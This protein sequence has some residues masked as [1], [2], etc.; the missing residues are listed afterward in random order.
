MWLLVNN[1]CTK[2]SD[3]QQIVF[4]LPCGVNTLRLHEPDWSKKWQC[5]LVDMFAEYRS[6]NYIFWGK[7]Q[8]LKSGYLSKWFRT[9]SES[10]RL[11]LLARRPQEAKWLI[12]LSIESELHLL[13]F[14]IAYLCDWPTKPAPLSQPMWN[15]MK[16]NW[17]LHVGIF[18]CLALARFN[19]WLALCTVLVCCDWLKEMLWFWFY[20][21]IIEHCS[22]KTD[23]KFF[24]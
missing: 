14:C 12:K 8:V 20:N 5:G 1:I 16:T 23:D 18:P 9:N 13:W 22:I 24:I 11:E 2:I 17:D 7:E 3:K 21:C 15:K 4:I 6:N 19:C 10:L